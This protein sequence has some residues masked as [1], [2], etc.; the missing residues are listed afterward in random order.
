MNFDKSITRNLTGSEK[1]DGMQRIFG[2]A[3]ALPMW[4]ADMD[5]ESPPAVIEAMQKR[6]EHGVFGYTMQTDEYKKSIVNWMK[7]RHDW[8]IDPEWLVF[9]PG[10][11]PAL[12]FAV[13]AFTEPGDQIVIQPPVYPPFHSVVQNHGRE[14]VLNPLKLEDGHYSMDL[15]G[16]E[17]ILTSGKIKMLILCSPHN[18]VGR[19]WT[20]AELDELIRLCS[21]HDVLVVSDE[22]HADLVYDGTKHTPLAKLSSADRIRSIICTSPSKTFNIAGLN[23]SNI[24]IPDPDTRSTFMKALQLYHV[25]S[26]SA[27]GSTAAEAAYTGGGEWLDHVLAY[28]QHNI[29]Y[30]IGFL[31]DR[32]P[33]IKAERPE[34]TYLLWLDFRSL[35]MTPE[36]TADFLLSKAK[37]ALNQG[38]A[39][40]QDGEGFMR[41]NIA[42]PKAT[43]VEAMDRLDAAMAQWRQE[44]NS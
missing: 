36:E 44:Q 32:I 10:V 40:G 1:W 37:L 35:G 19:V 6:V 12:S 38:A 25:G 5:F 26:I 20:T 23:T 34:A 17:Q 21:Q 31:R 39:F 11:V 29:D 28:L 33:E 41:M 4:V 14:L 2:T 16:L 27:I 15:E 24:I 30:V 42:C 18:P 3:D 8:A 9:C 7:E 43:V 13:Q 22:I